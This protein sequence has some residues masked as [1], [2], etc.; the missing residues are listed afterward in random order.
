M[1]GQTAE[2]TTNLI[3]RTVQ[4]LN[5]LDSRDFRKKILSMGSIPNV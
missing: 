1:S 3:F 5:G 2:L 4:N